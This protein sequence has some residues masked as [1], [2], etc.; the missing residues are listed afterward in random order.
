MP[1]VYQGTSPFPGGPP[2]DRA[3]G[4][5]PSRRRS[6]PLQN[7]AKL[8]LLTASSTG[9]HLV[10]REDFNT[11]LEARIRELRAGLPHAVGGSGG[12]WIY[13]SEP[14]GT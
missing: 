6:A 14:D 9:E 11:D 1:A 12:R 5:R 13:D 10:G 4:D 2:A 3:S 7:R 8:D